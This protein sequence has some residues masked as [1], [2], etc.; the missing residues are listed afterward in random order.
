[1]SAGVNGAYLNPTDPLAHTDTRLAWVQAKVRG[2][3]IQ[4]LVAIRLMLTTSPVEVPIMNICLV[5]EPHLLRCRLAT[6]ACAC[7]LAGVWVLTPAIAAAQPSSPRSCNKAAF[8]GRVGPARPAVCRTATGTTPGPRGPRGRTGGR[9]PAGFADLPGLAGPSGLQGLLGPAGLTGLT[10]MAGTPGTSGANG[11][12]G[13]PGADG[14]DGPPGAAGTAGAEGAVGAEGTAGAAGLA[15]AEGAAGAEGP[16]GAEGARGFAGLI[17]PGGS[18]GPRGFIGL[19]GPEG[20]NGAEG[21]K[22]ATGGTG[23]AGAE[24]PS[25]AKGVKGSTGEAGLEGPRGLIGPEGPAA[26]PSF[27][28]FYALMPPDNAATVGAGIPVEFPQTGPTVGGI[29]R[30]NA[31][32]FVLPSAGV[33]RVSFSVSVAEAGQLVIAL[34]SGS[35]M[36][37]LPYTVIGRATGTT[38]ISGEA[39]VKTVASNSAIELR[40]PTGNTPALTITPVAGGTHAA[41][42]FFVIQRL[43]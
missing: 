22:G 18:E 2:A 12:P 34:D 11:T 1:M 39:L 25:G 23:A 30:R 26:Q 5:F 42:A 21:T 37:E 19:P 31:T 38:P 7:A 3:P 9:G 16:A 41:S 8:T 24:G 29:V 6:N 36:I 40:N 35:G 17:G 28:E 43:G 32:E 15:G 10:G 13:T 20:A 27:A 14:N 4:L 33:Y